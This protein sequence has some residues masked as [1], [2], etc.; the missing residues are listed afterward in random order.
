MSRQKK[1]A[2]VLN[3]WGGDSI[4][5]AVNGGIVR[6]EADR[7]VVPKGFAIYIDGEDVPVLK[8]IGKGNAS[9]KK[10]GKR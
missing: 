5:I 3:V 8:F 10:G 6:F 1:T 2:D 7:M 4:N 9:Q